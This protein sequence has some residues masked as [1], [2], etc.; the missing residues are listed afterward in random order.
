MMRDAGIAFDAAAS[1]PRG[2]QRRDL[3]ALTRK[4][5]GRYYLLDRPE[6]AGEAFADQIAERCVPPRRT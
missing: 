6:D 2:S 1:E 4:G 5:D 3:E